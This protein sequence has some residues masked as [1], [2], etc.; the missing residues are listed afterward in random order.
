MS[1]VQETDRNYVLYRTER[2]RI[3]DGGDTF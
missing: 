3:N 2:P 1:T